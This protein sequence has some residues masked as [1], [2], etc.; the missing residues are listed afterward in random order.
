MFNFKNTN[1]YMIG[2]NNISLPFFGLCCV[3]FFSYAMIPIL[4]LSKG[5]CRFK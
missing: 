4:G 1:F 3:I 2:L 5:C